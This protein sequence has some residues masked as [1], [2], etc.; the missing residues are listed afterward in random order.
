MKK[1]LLITTVIFHLIQPSVVLGQTNTQPGSS[2][3]DASLG[4][5]WQG[6]K[7]KEPRLKLFLDEIPGLKTLSSKEQIEFLLYK[8]S[9]GSKIKMRQIKREDAVGT[10]AR[11]RDSLNVV[12]KGSDY[13]ELKGEASQI[14]EQWSTFKANSAKSLAAKN[15]LIELCGPNGF[16]EALKAQKVIQGRP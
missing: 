16:R 6:R 4:K 9:L 5:L 13:K 10:T 12:T 11:L 8:D 1:I 14:N 3:V 2:A 7:A 15:R